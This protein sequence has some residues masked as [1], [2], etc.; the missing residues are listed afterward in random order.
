M[1][2]LAGLSFL[3]VTHQSHAE[4]IAAELAEPDVPEV[5]LRA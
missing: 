3:C 2:G 1:M 4:A 5:I